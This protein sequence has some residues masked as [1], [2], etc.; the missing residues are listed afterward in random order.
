METKRLFVGGL[1]WKTTAEDLADFFASKGFA[2]AEGTTPVVVIGPDGRS[3]GF[4]FID[5]PADQLDAAVEATN[6]QQLEGRTL[7]VNEARPKEDRPP[8]PSFGGGDRGPRGGGFGG[9]N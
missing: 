9:N 7:T 2:P 1:P 5:V 8:R 6:M 3:K 4:G